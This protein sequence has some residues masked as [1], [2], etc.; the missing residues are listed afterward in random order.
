MNLGASS[1]LGFLESHKVK[2]FQNEKLQQKYQ[3]FMSFKN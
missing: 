3:K 2:R 1:D